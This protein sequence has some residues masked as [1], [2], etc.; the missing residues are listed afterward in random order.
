MDRANL[1]NSQLQGQEVG[2]VL[3]PAPI[4]G[5]MYLRTVALIGLLALTVPSV[6][7]A[8]APPSCETERAQL[9]FLVQK[10]GQERTQLEFA[11]AKAE[12]ERQ[13]LE[14]ELAKRGGE[15]K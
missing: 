14:A 1:Y 10:Y 7:A 15:G 13:R 11:L 2:K 3:S 9:R 5:A 6:S 12:A 8:Q 4:G